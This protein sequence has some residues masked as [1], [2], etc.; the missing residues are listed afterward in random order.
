MEFHITRKARDKYQFDELLFSY[1]GNVIFAN[2]QASRNFAHQMNQQRADTSD[3]SSYIAPGQIN[4]LGLIDEI[5]HLIFNEYYKANGLALRHALYTHLEKSLG[6]PRLLATLKSFNQQFPPVAVYADE[7]SIDEYLADSTDGV[8]NAENTVEELLM[9]W[10]TNVNP[11]AN[12][13]REIFDDSL[14]HKNSAYLQVIDGIQIFFKKQP[15]FGPKNQDLVTMLRTPALVVPASLTG[16]L[17]YIRT[18]WS[19]LLGSLLYRLLGGLD[20]LS[21]EARAL[22]IAAGGPGPTVVPEYGKLDAWGEKLSE[23]ENFSPDSDWMPKVVMMA[24]NSFVWL[25]QLSKEYGRQIERLDQIPDETLDQLASWGFTGLW[26]IGL[27]ERSDASRQIKQMCGNPDA[28]S[29]AYSL[30]RYQIAERL[31]GDLSYNNLSQRC[32]ARGIRLASDMVPNHMGIDSNWVYDHPD[33]FIQSDQSPFPAYTFNGADLSTRPGTSINLE[34]HYYTRSDAAVVF[35]HYDHASGRTRYIYHGNDGTSMPWNDTAQLDYL[36]P[37]VREAVIQTIL[38]VARKFPIIRFDAAMTLTKKHFQ[39]LWFPQPGSGGDIPSRAEHAM[40]R[41]AFDAAMPE[42][43]WREVVQRVADEVP[44]TL[45]LAEAFWLME[46]Y[47]VRTLGMHRVYN[48]AFMNMLRN[49]ENEKYRQL[50]K[51]TLVYDPEILKRYVNFMNNPDEKTAVEQY[52]KG[53]KYFGICALLSTMPGLPMFGHGQIEGYSEKYGM[54]YYRPY[55]DESPDQDLIRHHQAVIFPLLHK[56]KVFANVNRFRLFDFHLAG[57]AVNENVFAYTNHQDGQSALVVYHNKYAETSGW[58]H[59][60]APFLVKQGSEGHLETQNLAEALEL[61]GS[62]SDLVLFQDQISKRYYLRRLHEIREGGLFFTLG[63]Y[64]CQVLMNFKIVSGSYY[65]LLF[66]R[67]DGRGV[68][69]LDRAMDE[70][71]HE[72][73]L[74]PLGQALSFNNLIE[75]AEIS[76]D[77]KAAQKNQTLIDRNLA[78]LDQA[79]VAARSIMDYPAQDREIARESWIKQLEVLT[80]LEESSQKLGLAASKTGKELSRTLLDEIQKDPRKHLLLLVW[81]FFSNLAGS[82]EEESVVE[83]N[84]QITDRGPVSDLLSSKLKELGFSEYEAYRGSQAIRWLIDRVPVIEEDSSSQEFLESL[85]ADPVITDYLEINTHNGIRW[86]NKE[87]FSDLIWYQRAVRFVRSASSDL[88]STEVFEAILSQE[89]LLKE[90]EKAVE[91][92]GYQLDKLIE[93]LA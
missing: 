27:W 61:N 62:Y 3:T 55:W 39:R 22:M 8:P 4:A 92:S 49:E 88:E 66:Q 60:S 54:E 2:F 5:F 15:V 67:L 11:A 50:I 30:A 68:T 53:D 79:D 1:N 74:D 17:E 7:Q 63:S 10:L 38:S 42:E 33:W 40:T 83:I 80:S 23:E 47:F 29:S 32:A 52:G 69:D 41:E 89:R 85:L 82:I 45:L 72:H 34:D 35:K 12:S 26:L 51:N 18:N 59:L 81:N 14:L 56:R 86:F 24:K 93:L 78:W 25:N 48:S 44:D 6:K 16:Q 70:L 58:I 9:T 87:K 31:G 76:T 28:V 65:E 36:N 13:Y 64:S 37:E 91:D 90:L 71:V 43:F 75:L 84:R 57:G 77:P 20:L 19:G 73:L 21:E 46:G